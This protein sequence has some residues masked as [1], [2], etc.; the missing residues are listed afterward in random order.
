[1]K[2]RFTPYMCCFI[3]S[4][5][6]CLE[7]FF[8]LFSPHDIDFK[9]SRIVVLSHILALFDSFFV[10]M[11]KLTFYILCLCLGLLV[12][13]LRWYSLIIT[14]LPFFPSFL[15]NLSFFFLTLPFVAAE[16]S[17]GG[18]MSS[19][20]WNRGGDFKGRKWDTDL[21][22]DAAVSLEFCFVFSVLLL[23][24]CFHFSIIKISIKKHLETKVEIKN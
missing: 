10:V 17:Q 23:G 21:P 19:F 13:F 8:H 16:L 2:S 24:L 6:P 4:W 9:E 1:M 5:F 12:K 14:S 20:R 22:T 7:Q 11:F 15:H 18:C 3:P